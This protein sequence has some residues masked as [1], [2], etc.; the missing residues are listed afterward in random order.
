MRADWGSWPAA[1]NLH[2][3]NAAAGVALEAAAAAVGLRVTRYVINYGRSFDGWTIY[4]LYT[5]ERPH[6]ST[7]PRVVYALRVRHSK[8]GEPS[9]IGEARILEGLRVYVT[10]VYACPMA[11]RADAPY[12]IVNGKVQRKG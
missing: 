10:E 1:P 8:Y 4:A 7:H 3:K 6:T 5:G 2:A 9:I 11:L 12:I